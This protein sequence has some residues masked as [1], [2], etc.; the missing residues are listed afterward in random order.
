MDINELRSERAKVNERIQALAPRTDLTQAEEQEFAQLST[1]FAELTGQISRA[2][3]AERIAIE[4][5]VPAQSFSATTP[6]AKASAQ[7]A[8]ARSSGVNVR[9]H[10]AEEL[11]N[12]MVLAASINALW[13]AG[14]NQH[15]A[16][17]LAKNRIGFSPDV[18]A[19]VVNGFEMAMNSE[20]AG[21]GGVFI[22]TALA[23]GV[24][25]FLYPTAVL[26]N[27]GQGLININLPNGNLDIGRISVPPVVSYTG[28]N[29]AVSVTGLG[30]DKVSL[31]AKKATGLVPIARDL[32]RY[33]GINVGIESLVINSLGRGASAAEDIAFIRGDGTGDNI[34]GFRYWAP[35]QNVMSATP[36]AGKSVADGTLQQ[37]VVRDLGRLEGALLNSNVQIVNGAWIMNPRTRVYLTD[38]RTSTGA[39]VYPELQV[40]MAVVG[41]D[42]ITRRQY[43]LKGLPIGETTQIPTNLTSGGAIGNGSEIY[44]VEL[45]YWVRGDGVPM[46]IGISTE[47]SYTDPLSGKQVSAFEKD[48]TLIRIVA[49]NDLGP[50]QVVAVSVLDG[51][52]WGA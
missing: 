3:T 11:H 21:A 7:A 47:A 23:P 35:A 52:T 51:V 5:A 31:K 19:G 27:L 16:L 1:R 44:L 49:E 41:K 2:E 32:I 4:A 33:A 24:I 22:P 37:A 43:F 25:D 28:R 12:R 36:L 6:A 34:K 13:Q 42:G 9:D 29:N 40:P 46:E 50:F 15:A 30:T 45:S 38:L 17:D 48:E 18:K 26:R 8:P 10:S 39:P 20:S 14:G